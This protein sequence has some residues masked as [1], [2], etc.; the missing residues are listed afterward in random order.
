MK[1]QLVERF[2][3]QRVIWLEVLQVAFFCLG[4]SLNSRFTQI[5]SALEYFRLLSV[6]S[7]MQDSV[8]AKLFLAAILLSKQARKDILQGD[9]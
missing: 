3:L 2:I 7:K 1:F 9:A 4:S 6:S 8:A 5:F